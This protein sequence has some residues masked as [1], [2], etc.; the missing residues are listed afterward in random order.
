MGVYL[1]AKGAAGAP[2]PVHVA[3]GR[4][5]ILIAGDQRFEHQQLDRHRQRQMLAQA[6]GFESGWYAHKKFIFEKVAQPGQR[7]AGGRLGQRQGLA[8]EGDRTGAVNGREDAQEVEV[9]LAEIQFSIF[10]DWFSGMPR[11]I[12]QMDVIYLKNQFSE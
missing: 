8:G 4:F 6:R 9:K 11:V 3:V 7:I 10:R 1:R 5:E 12:R 2:W